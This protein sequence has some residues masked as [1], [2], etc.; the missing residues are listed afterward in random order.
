MLQTLPDPPGPDLCNPPWKAVPSDHGTLPRKPENSGSDADQAFEYWKLGENV[1]K[2]YI[3]GTATLRDGGETV[4]VYGEATKKDL[5]GHTDE[6]GNFFKGGDQLVIQLNPDKIEGT[7][8][9]VEKPGVEITIGGFNTE[10]NEK[11][12]IEVTGDGDDGG[13]GG[14]DPLPTPSG[15]ITIQLPADI[16]YSISEGNAPAKADAII[17]APKGLKNVIVKIIPGN[18]DFADILAKLKLGEVDDPNAPTFIEGADIVNNKYLETVFSEVGQ[19]ISAPKLGETEPYTF[20]IGNFFTFLNLTGATESGEAHQ[21]VI[22]VTD[23]EGNTADGI[24]KVT[25]NE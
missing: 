22:K 9:G 5:Q 25:I 21:F 4:Q 15:D 13:D 20:P 12:E 10:T 8:A 23:N 17:S 11:I 1:D 7:T 16:T 6:D 19:S 24:L 2:I 14:D 3:S 18:D